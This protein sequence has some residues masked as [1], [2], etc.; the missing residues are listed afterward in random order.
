[1]QARSLLAV[2]LLVLGVAWGD[3]T[4]RG[5][6]EPPY[7]LSCTSLWT[8]LNDAPLTIEPQPF[9]DIFLVDAA[10]KTVNGIRATF[11]ESEISWD[12]EAWSKNTVS[13]DRTTHFANR[14]TGKYRVLIRSDQIGPGHQRVCRSVRAKTAGMIALKGD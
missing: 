1:M 10:Q 11:S 5:S 2:A 3:V 8:R 12:N 4:A 14:T 7:A 6:S 13:A 9:T